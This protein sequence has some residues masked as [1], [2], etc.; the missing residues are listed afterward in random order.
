[1]D[2]ANGHSKEPTGRRVSR[3]VVALCFVPVA[4]V[5][6]VS[7]AAAQAAEDDP[8]DPPVLRRPMHFNG[9]VGSYSVTMTAEPAAVQ[10]GDPLTLVVRV[11]GTAP[12]SDH[13]PQRPNLRRFPKFDQFRIEDARDHDRYLP[14][15]KGFAGVR[16]PVG[17]LFALSPLGPLSV[18]PA[19]YLKPDE[20][21]WEFHY[22]LR[23][24]EATVKGI[25]SWPFVYY[26]P[27]AVN[28]SV[29][30]YQT[31]YV[32]KVPVQ[33]TP[34]A[35]VQATDVQGT[36]EPRAPARLYRIVEGPAVLRSDGA[37]TSPGPWTITLFALAALLMPPLLTLAWYAA[38]RHRYPDA[39]R[40]ARLRRSQAAER[41]LKALR[42]SGADGTGRAA[43][44]VSGYLRERLD[45]RSAEPT[46]AEV[47][48]HLERS[49]ISPPL[50]EKAIA[51]FHTC[52]A[53]RFAPPSAAAQDDLATAATKLILALEVELWLSRAS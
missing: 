31:T 51:F 30:S 41:A 42:T 10:V 12:S 3:V 1:M 27:G 36:E 29:G 2:Q 26:R 11:H 17:G 52:D 32:P 15:A 45:L 9:A 33:V 44:A 50:A 18:L 35:Q 49:G 7:R 47:G 43:A 19:L 8:Y 28:P 20:P 34:R 6:G 5:L 48:Q 25:P 37:W 53:A 22:R 46:P 14:G 23:P 24:R 4:L 38:W 40:L 39:A 16:G 21:T 13:Q